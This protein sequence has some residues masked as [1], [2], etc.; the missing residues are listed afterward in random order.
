MISI[1]RLIVLAG[2]RACG[3]ST[4][5]SNPSQFIDESNLPDV[6]AGL[7]RLGP[8]QLTIQRL[9]RRRMIRRKTLWLHIDLITPIA[10]WP[11]QGSDTLC[12]KL[13]R[14]IF[15]EWPELQ[16]IRAAR[17][18]HFVSMYVSRARLFDRWLK[19]TVTQPK[20]TALKNLVNIY[21][22]SDHDD[23]LYHHLMAAWW[24]YT[25]SY[26][27]ASHW[28]LHADSKKYEW[29][30]MREPNAFGNPEQ[31]TTMLRNSRQPHPYIQLDNI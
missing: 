4:F 15:E 24:H 18:L 8:K 30:R 22:N 5:L 21:G 23:E 27:D 7:P 13:S 3:K 10:G 20:A 19:R 9:A 1:D 6:F 29:I 16:L 14:S 17:E 31:L 11:V 25:S 12:R 26:T 2:P 28:V